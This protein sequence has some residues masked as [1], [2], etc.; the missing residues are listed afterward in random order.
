MEKNISELYKDN[1]IGIKGGKLSIEAFFDSS[2]LKLIEARIKDLLDCDRVDIQTAF[3]KGVHYIRVIYKEKGGKS[4]KFDIEKVAYPTEHYM[5]LR[6]RGFLKRT[7]LKL[8]KKKVEKKLNAGY[9]DNIILIERGLI[10][11][12]MGKMLKHLQI[13]YI[14]SLELKADQRD[15]S[16]VHL[17]LNLNF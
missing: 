6:W 9:E 14:K 3:R 11:I 4:R 13:S 2:F 7:V 12:D 16:G 15:R 10:H 8:F 1:F 17:N 5:T